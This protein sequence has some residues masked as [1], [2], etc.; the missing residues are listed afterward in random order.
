MARDVY[1][2]L[3]RHLDEL[4]A[5]FPATDSGVELRILERLFTPEEAELALK[6]T[7][8]PET[9]KVIARRAGLS[10]DQ[11][12]RRLDQM[13]RKGLIFRYQYQG[14]THYLAAQFA[15]GI[16]EFHV[17]QLDQGLI[18][19]FD[20]Y[21]PHLVDPELWQKAPQMRTIPVQK[22]LSPEHQVMDY[23][24]AEELVRQQ[25]HLLVAPCICRR[26]HRLVG[27][28]CSHPEESCLVFGAGVDFYLQMGVGRR[29]DQAEALDIIRE[30]E[31]S[32]RVLQPSNS[33][34][35]VLIC[36]CC[37]C[38]CRV[39]QILGKEPNPGELVSS[40]FRARLEA[41]T[42]AACGACL[43]R[44]PMEAFT[45]DHDDTVHLDPRRCIGCG[46]CVT[47]CPTGALSLERKPPQQQRPVPANN[48]EALLRLARARGKL[49]PLAL[50]RMSLKSKL[51]RLRAGA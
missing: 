11:T 12:R 9:A 3:R 36:T 13:A 50:A 39:L 51:D 4:P 26:E 31:E 40:P 47:T 5:G 8:I 2:R 18:R 7:L 6:V 29:I 15:V 37:S 34:K 44:C 45:Q 35:A 16:W 1:Q 32:G 23:E 22:S 30:A 20:Q 14:Q 33:R 27:K 17:D 25:K 46:L 41:E 43:E 38:C 10:E 28:G 21:L 48:L 19:D 24:R 49:G 42:C